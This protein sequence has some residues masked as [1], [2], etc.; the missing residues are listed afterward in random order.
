M[1]KL[2]IMVLF[3]LTAGFFLPKSVWAAD[4]ITILYESMGKPNPH[5]EMD[6]GYAVLI[7]YD[8]KRI[9]FDAGK[10]ANIFEKN[11]KALGVDL[12][13]LDAVILSHRHH[14]HIV[15]TEYLYT[16]NPDVK[17]YAPK[18]PH[19]GGNMPKS[20]FKGVA[21]L[22]S[23]MRYFGGNPP[24]KVKRHNYMPYPNIINVAKKTEI[25]PGFFLIPNKS[26]IGP[27]ISLH[28]RSPQGQI[29]VTGCAHPGIE[30][31][32][33]SSKDIDSRIK[34]VFGGLHWVKKTPEQIDKLVASLRDKWQVQ[35]IGCA[36]CTGEPGSAAL[37]EAFGDKYVYSGLGEVIDI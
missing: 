28:M 14:D 8:G 2:V 35:K 13:T 11:T 36:H 17:V 34:S 30:T 32:L 26:Y 22:P 29:V 37:L 24:E 1:K 7:E 5:L 31:I 23:E 20:F 3:L 12:T 19:F 21:S 16:I 10:D 9:L 25:F 18:D 33:E 27:E 6:W 4:R 15:G